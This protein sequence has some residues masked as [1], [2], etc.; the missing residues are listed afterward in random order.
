MRRI[1]VLGVADRELEDVGEAP[2]A[3]LAEQE[4]PAAERPRHAR[5]EHASPRNELVAEL[6][7]PFDRRRGGAT[8]WPHRASGSPRS[9]DKTAGTSP[10][11]PF[12][13]GSTT[14]S[15]K[16]VATAASNAFP[17]RS[18]TDIPA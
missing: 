2:R 1:A 15:T 3:E 14:W 8:P 9:T 12:R 13:C 18:S 11:G 6:A 7:E 17:P 10:P 16:P 5:G 4:Q